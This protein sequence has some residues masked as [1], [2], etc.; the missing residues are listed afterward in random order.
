MVLFQAEG[1]Q[2]DELG[3]GFG[4]GSDAVVMEVEGFELG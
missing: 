1:L 4:D 3:D 2:V